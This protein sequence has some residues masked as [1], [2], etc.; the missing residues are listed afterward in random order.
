MSSPIVG[1]FVSASLGAKV[2]IT[3][4]DDSTGS[5]KGSVSIGQQTWPISGCWN[6]STMH[7]QAVF[8]F[9]GGYA[10]PQSCVVSGVGASLNCFNNFQDTTIALS[11]AQAQ[12]KVTTISGAFAFTK[13]A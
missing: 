1:S 13:G 10:N 5:I 4:A 3:S 11:F 8:Y 6:T 12:G 7:P 2:I 9:T